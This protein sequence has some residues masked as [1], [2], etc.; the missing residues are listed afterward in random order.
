M[1]RS[2]RRLAIV[3][4]TL[5][6]LVLA[7]PVG[8]WSA[9]GHRLIG[10][11]AQR[12]LTPA[13]RA[14][15]AELLADEPTP[16]L[17]GVATWADTLRDSDPARFKATSRWHYADMTGGGCN[18]DARRDCPD[19]Q[20]VVGA[21]EAQRKVLA[22]RSQPV[23]ARREALKFLVHFVGDVHQ[24]LHSSNHR[25][26]GGNKY[27]VSLTTDLEPE[28]YARDKYDR[29][30]HVMGTNLHSVWDYYILGER[31][32]SVAAY[33]DRLDRQPWPPAGGLLSG[34]AAW[35]GESCR[36]IDARQ[37]YPTTA[38]GAEEHKLDHR[39]N[40]AQRAL[41][42]QRVR[43]AAWRLS[44]LLNETLVNETPGKP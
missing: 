25:D 34:A 32:L 3:V 22:D 15:V 38:S 12:H 30:T 2:T 43:Q 17:A 36:L 44:N 24:P 5:L 8:A 19:G 9:L 26:L 33:A 4:P 31:G 10:E 11:L 23:E 27:Q 1:R 7:T 35:A 6:L 13:A 42:E 29:A 37:L 16:T 21:I 28:A 20:C 40:D 18:F 39:Y 41:A 14:Q